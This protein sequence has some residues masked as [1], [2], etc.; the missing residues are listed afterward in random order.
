MR[1]TV[2]G[3]TGATGRL[4][5]QQALDAGHAVTAY[6]RTPGKL[7]ERPGL[8][9]IAGTL[10]DAA[11]VRQ[12]VEGADAVVSLLGPG[13]DKAGTAALVPGTRTI[14]A[15][16][17]AAGVRR[18]VA[19]A[20]PSAPD[21]SDGR[22][23]RLAVMVGAIRIAMRP[24][25]DAIRGVADV[26]R[27]SSLDWTLVRLPLLHDKPRD[28]APHPRRVGESGSLRLSR[29]GLAAF[30]LQEAETGAFT[31]TSPLLADA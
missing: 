18:L 2:F 16:M 9:V 19:T 12:A 23:L 28:G 15:A 22:D 27:A 10:D 4:L 13:K 1:L 20:T 25:Y 11:A 3:G 6:A 17:T 5:I 31:G 24:A 30:L 14:V 8:T 26:V 21:P 7:P 29:P